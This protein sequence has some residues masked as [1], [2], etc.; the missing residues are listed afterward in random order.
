MISIT[1][2]E[3][4]EVFPANQTITV[5]ATVTDNTGVHMVHVIVVDD[6]GGHWVHSEEHVDGRTYEV[7]KTFIATAG[8]TYTTHIDATE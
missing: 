1:S 7:N 6:A 3:P 5:K 4:N 2:P 8:K